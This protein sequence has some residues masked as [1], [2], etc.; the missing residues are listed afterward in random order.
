MLHYANIGL[1]AS[2]TKPEDHNVLRYWYLELHPLR[3]R[4]RRLSEE[5]LVTTA[6]NMYRE[7]RE[8]CHD[9]R[10]LLMAKFSKSRDCD[11]VPPGSRPIPSFRC[12]HDSR[13]PRVEPWHGVCLCLC[14]S[15]VEV[16]L[17]CLDGPS[18]FL[19]WRLLSTSPALCFKEIQY[20]Q[21]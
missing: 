18:C 2:F 4:T 12:Q 10:A 6:G 21:K 20:L 9:R 5:D 14:L 8:V 17:K 19:A 16:L 3:L 7:F 11:I 1:H 13:L 15:Q